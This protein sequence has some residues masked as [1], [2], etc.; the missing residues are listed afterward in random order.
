MPQ[1]SIEELQDVI[2]I[3][4]RH[5]KAKVNEQRVASQDGRKTKRFWDRQLSLD[6]SETGIPKLQYPRGR[7]HSDSELVW[8]PFNLLA[9]MARPPME[10]DCDVFTMLS[11]PSKTTTQVD[12]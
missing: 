4:Q 5:L 12:W 2:R 8:S 3:A 10:I 9:G 1:F 7:S 6:W 11:P